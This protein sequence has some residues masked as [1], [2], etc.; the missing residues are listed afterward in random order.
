MK[1][2]KLPCMHIIIKKV[3]AEL[4]NLG[5]GA[6]ELWIVVRHYTKMIINEYVEV[7]HVILVCIK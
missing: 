7:Q 1:S 5:V 4:Q 3:Y 2:K 6:K